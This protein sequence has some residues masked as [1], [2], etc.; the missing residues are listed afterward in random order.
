[1]WVAVVDHIVFKETQ[2]YILHL[3]QN[4][5]RQ[6]RASFAGK[7]TLKKRSAAKALDGEKTPWWKPRAGLTTVA[8]INKSN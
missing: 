8:G 7:S 5:Q 2:A 3:K 6:V 1:L 4:N